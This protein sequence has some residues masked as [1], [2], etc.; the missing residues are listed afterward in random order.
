[1]EKMMVH[2]AFLPDN[3]TL[4]ALLGGMRAPPGK[5]IQ[6]RFALPT[7]DAA[8]PYLGGTRTISALPPSALGSDPGAVRTLPPPSEAN[9]SSASSWSTALLTELEGRLSNLTTLDARFAAFARWLE[10]RTGAESVFVADSEGLGMV[11]STAGETYVAAAAAID[12]LRRE[13]S[14]LIP[15]VESGRTTLRPT[16]G[17]HVELIWCE[18]SL[19][20][21]TVGLVLAQPLGPAWTDAVLTALKDVVT[22]HHNRG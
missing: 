5:A 11:Q 10:E 9:S 4:T 3:A 17:S 15:N 18:T 14:G 20:R 19:G 12:S 2:S 8:P 1:M 7:F 13:L 21:Y 6:A 16:S 22:I